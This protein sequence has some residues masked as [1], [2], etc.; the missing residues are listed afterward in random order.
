MQWLRSFIYFCT[1]VDRDELKNS[2]SP[3]ERGLVYASFARQIIGAAFVFV[4]FLYAWATILPLWMAL[5]ISAVL[6]IIV[7]LIDQ[8]IIS[9]EWMFHREF[10]QSTLL[11]TPAN[12]VFKVLQLTPRIIYAVLI[13]AFMSTLAEIAI[14]SREIERV[15]KEATREVNQEY[16]GR[17]DKLQTEQDNEASKVAKKIA[18]LESSIAL[19]TNPSAQSN[20]DILKIKVGQNKS[21]IATLTAQ[22][23]AL[24]QELATLTADSTSVSSEITSYN[25][26][27]Q[28]YTEQMAAEISPERCRAASS[29][30]FN[31]ATDAAKCQKTEWGKLRDAKREALKRLGELQ[32]EAAGISAK[33]TKVRAEITTATASL[34]AADAG[35][36]KATTALSGAQASGSSLVE[37]EDQLRAQKA[38]LTA[39]LGDPEKGIISSHEVAMDELV[40]EL[41]AAGY[42]DEADYGPLEL[43][44]GL[45]R[46]HNPTIP[47]GATEQQAERLKLEGEAAR[48]FSKGLWLIIIL[49]ELS[50]VLVTFLGAPFSHLSMRMREK[51]D[52]AIRKNRLDSI[53]ADESQIH[54]YI[55]AENSIKAARHNGKY[56]ARKLLLDLKLRSTQDKIENSTKTAEARAKERKAN[57]TS[58]GKN[59]SISDLDIQEAILRKR[60]EVQKLLN[61]LQDLEWEYQNSEVLTMDMVHEVRANGVQNDGK[62]K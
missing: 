40:R 27:V 35:F 23:K 26:L 47:E 30:S 24:N 60:I 34:A 28:S 22:L 53:K 57:I 36:T 21:D 42:Y 3:H 9:S 5:I 13:A 44:V 7:F 29:P 51:R 17:K 2:N 52:G 59:S 15:L 48:D 39:M 56:E 37:L 14:Q 11:N 49:F 61:E 19:A 31:P 41:R 16:F 10:F 25:N 33:L 12:F 62:S 55:K 58:E 32:A 1:Q 38:I 6:A 46:M 50:P 18:E 20:I 4:V 54:E 8:A 43:Y 45:K